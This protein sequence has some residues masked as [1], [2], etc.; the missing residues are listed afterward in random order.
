MLICSECRNVFTVVQADHG[1]QSQFH[2]CVQ[3]HLYPAQATTLPKH[4]LPDSLVVN[5]NTEKNSKS[6]INLECFLLFANYIKK[7][8]YFVFIAVRKRKYLEISFGQ[9]LHQYQTKQEQ[10]GPSN[11]AASHMPAHSG[12]ISAVQQGIVQRYCN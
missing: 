1:Q 12:Y 2:K 10:T 11:S 7:K 9:S 6:S 3:F 8:E 5:A 4:T